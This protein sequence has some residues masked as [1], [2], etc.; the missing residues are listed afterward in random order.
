MCAVTGEDGPDHREILDRAGFCFTYGGETSSVSHECSDGII[1][2]LMKRH[3]TLYTEYFCQYCR[4]YTRLLIP[5]E[6]RSC[7]Y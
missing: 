2:P 6:I 5:E 4:R 1:K 3:D 7:D